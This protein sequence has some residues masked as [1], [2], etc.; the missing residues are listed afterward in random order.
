MPSVLL[1]NCPSVK[2]RA[3]L[4]LRALKLVK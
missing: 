4:K 1:A 2:L 3:S